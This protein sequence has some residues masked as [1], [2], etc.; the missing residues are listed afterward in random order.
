MRPWRARIAAW[1]IGL[2]DATIEKVVALAALMPLVANMGGI[3]GT[4]TL[5]AVVRGMAL[6]RLERSQIP[7]MLRRELFSAAVNGL[8]W[9]ALMGGL[10]LLWSGNPLL[11]AVVGVALLTNQFAAALAGA[12]MPLL[13][14]RFRIDPALAGGVI[15]TTVTDV[16]GFFTL[17]GLGSAVLLA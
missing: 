15:L 10:A 14:E 5:T 2:F 3:A 6:G 11:G 17:L 9:A 4:Q 13:L 7:W 12:V 8:V 16:V 1:V